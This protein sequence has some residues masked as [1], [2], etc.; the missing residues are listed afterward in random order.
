MRIVIFGATGPTGILTL[1]KALKSGHHVV[2]YAR[3]PS[4]VTYEHPN[5]SLVKGELSNK[6]LIADTIKG[7]NAVISVLGP[8][9]KSTPDLPLAQGMKHIVSGMKLHHVKRLI[10]TATPSASDPHDQYQFG[11]S[12]A[13]WMV[14][15][16]MRS[17]YDEIVSIAQIIRNSGLDWTLVRLP[18][19]TDKPQKNPVT[20]GYIGHGTINLFWLNRSDLADFIVKQLDDHTFIH[21]A[22][23]VSN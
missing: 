12:V 6:Q 10:A 16:L 8:K 13:V 3:D 7:A 9:G 17:T 2:V 22:P 19:L 4:K 23:A 18:M 21:K 20:A 11:F 14:K 15:N 5:I 1:T